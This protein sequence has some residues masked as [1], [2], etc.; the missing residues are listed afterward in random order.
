MSGHSKVRH[1]VP[2][3][4]L[5]V[6]KPQKLGRHY[7]RI[8]HYIKDVTLK[9]PRLVSDYFLRNFRINIELL[10]VD[11]QEQVL[12]GPA[13][14]YRSELGKI[15]FAIDRALLSEALEC[16]YGGMGVPGRETS[17]VTTSEQR[18]R[19][20]L[21]VDI[22]QIFG[23]SLL[24]GESLGPLE[25]YENDYEVTEWEYVAEFEYNSHITGNRS[26]I[27]I[28]I[29]TQLA[30]ELTSRLAGP[31]Q[32]SLPG[33]PIDG[34]KHLP[35]RLDCVVAAAQMP[36]SQVLALALDDV[37]LM[38]PL[39]RYEIRVAGQRLYRGTVFEEDGAL[40]LT[41]LE[42]VKTP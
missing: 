10:R 16:Y 32:P 35:V 4:S 33:N 40:F 20:R 15:G 31:V 19:E 1:D 39:D 5:T 8:P 23:R 29:D 14:I 30:D 21:G 6:L 7:H 22:S 37:L 17:A 26:S 9:H 25:K 12:N 38:R 11:V 27:F 28:Y 34:I 2:A 18:I 36:L 41:S 3:D 13:C 24:G 42:S